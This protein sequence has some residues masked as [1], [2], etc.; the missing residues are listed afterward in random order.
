[1]KTDKQLAQALL[2]V[3]ENGYPSPL[4]SIVGKRPVHL[5]RYAVLGL[6]TYFL[7]T[8]WEDVEMRSMI[9]LGL[10]VLIG[11]IIT[12][13]KFYKMI[14]DSWPFTKRVTDWNIVASLAEQP[15]QS[16]EEQS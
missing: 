14:G 13:M 4:I 10:G 9:L 12:E 6:F 2:K 5:L 16:Q 3:K 15:E 1:M 7:A 8:Q 11:G